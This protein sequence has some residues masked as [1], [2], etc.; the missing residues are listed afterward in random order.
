M[1]HDNMSPYHVT[2]LC[3]H[4]MSS[5]VD[6]LCFVSPVLVGSVVVGSVVIQAAIMFDVLVKCS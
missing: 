5:Q 4:D 1:C 3:H 2:T 6:E